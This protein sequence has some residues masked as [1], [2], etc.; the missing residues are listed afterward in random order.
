MAAK[1]WTA[2]IRNSATWLRLLFMLIF[3]VVFWVV[4]IV[5]A[6]LVVLQFGFSLFAGKPN[7]QLTRFGGQLARYFHDIVAYLSYRS[8][9][10]PFPFSE[11]P[12]DKGGASGTGAAKPARKTT[13][14]KSSSSAGK[15]G[16]TAAR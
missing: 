15:S 1:N 4:E 6:V 11:W 14:R 8:E 13:A 3:V 10:R 7:P 5:L 9:V 16:G 12:G 2:N